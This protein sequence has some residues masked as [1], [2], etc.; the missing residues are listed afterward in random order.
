MAATDARPVPRKN[1][2]YRFSFALRKNDGSLCAGWAGADSEISKDG[3]AFADCTNEATEIGSS[4][5][6]YIDLTAAEMN[7]DSVILKITVTNPG[8]LPLVFTFF[9]EELG[10]YRVSSDVNLVSVNGA[11]VLVGDFNFTVSAGGRLQKG[12]LELIPGD[13][14]VIA[15][16]TGILFTD[17]NFPDLDGFTSA[18]LTVKVGAVVVIDHHSTSSLDESSKTV[19]FSMA[20]TVSILL[21]D[22]VGQD[23]EFDVEAHR[24]DGSCKTI[25]RGPAVI[26]DPLD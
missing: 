9:P 20:D 26:L 3:G 16:G 4:G 19:S 8:A 22:Y 2:A 11:S 7:A 18:K 5:C 10:D 17:G 25:A 12:S 1:A 15:D 14:Y 6:G 24:P 13:D 23:A 21:A